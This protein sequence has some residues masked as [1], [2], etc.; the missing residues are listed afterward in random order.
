VFWAG[1][2]L[3]TAAHHVCNPTRGFVALAQNESTPEQVQY[4]A[5]VASRIKVKLTKAWCIEF[6]FSYCHFAPSSSSR[7]VAK[8]SLR[9]HCRGR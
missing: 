6:C 1:Q 2:G 8:F 7:L 3:V 4:Q 9:A 5:K